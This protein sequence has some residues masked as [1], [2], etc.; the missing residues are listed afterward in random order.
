AA[1][2]LG[3]APALV[4]SHQFGDGYVIG[5]RGPAH[6]VDS[7]DFVEGAGAGDSL[8]PRSLYVDQLDRRL[9]RTTPPRSP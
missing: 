5:T 4:Y 1:K 3:A 8:R 7:S 6:D 2:R 9:G